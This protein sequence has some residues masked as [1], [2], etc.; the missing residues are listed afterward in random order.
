MAVATVTAK[1]QITIPKVVRDAMG[2]EVGDRLEFVL[3]DDGV[4]E[5]FARNRPLLS[6]AGMLGERTVP[7]S[8]DEMDAGIGEQVSRTS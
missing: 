3:R 5:M 4:V 6:L 2:V 8:L 1:G 7:V